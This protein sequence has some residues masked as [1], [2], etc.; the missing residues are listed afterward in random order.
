MIPQ[1]I[2]PSLHLTVSILYKDLLNQTSSGKP[3]SRRVLPFLRAFGLHSDHTS[4]RM[5]VRSPNGSEEAEAPYWT[6]GSKTHIMA[7]INST[8]DSF[9]D[10]GDRSTVE[11][12][13]AFVNTFPVIPA[14]DS[15]L[16]SSSSSLNTPTSSRVD[17]ID[18]GGYSTRPGALPVSPEE[19]I[20]RTIPI[21]EAIRASADS[22]TRS[23]LISIDTFRASV[24]AAALKAGA[25][26]VNDVYGLT[27]EG[28]D[29]TGILDVVRHAGCPVIM[30]HSRGDAGTNKIY[31]KGVVIDVRDELGIKVKRALKAGVRRWNIIVDPGIGFSKTVEDN[32]TLVRR[33]DDFTCDES[34]EG[35]A[36]A[37]ATQS[38]RSCVLSA[39]PLTAMPVLVGASRK[40][41]LGALMGRPEASAKDRTAATV[42]VHTAAVERGADVL[43]VHDVTEAWDSI[44]VADKLWRGRGGGG[45]HVVELRSRTE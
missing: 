13:L 33:L 36:A 22:I 11:S 16:S 42:A 15:S 2:H 34:G 18:V 27:G 10:G 31:E 29:D 39:H 28:E 14:A 7:I 45:A 43:R 26:V 32:L 17:I 41:F 5:N 23:T 44:Q 25:D 8:P 38:L 21:I 4:N 12:A 19:E 9:S 1:Y 20:R 40:S 24:A 35:G 37:E 3:Q 6:W 30:M